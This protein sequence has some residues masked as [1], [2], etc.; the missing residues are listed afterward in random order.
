ML[1]LDIA[2]FIRR[3]VNILLVAVM[4]YTRIPVLGRAKYSED[5]LN[6]STVYLPIVGWLVG[7]ITYVVFLLASY[8]FTPVISLILAVAAGILTTGAFHEDG[9]AD[10]CDGFGGGF[11]KRHILA[12]MQDSRLGTYGV[13]GLVLLFALKA[14][15]LYTIVTD[16]GFLTVLGVFVTGHSLSRWAA[17]ATVFTHEYAREDGK[18]KA[19]PV[20]KALPKRDLVIVS[21]FGLAPLAVSSVLLQNYYLLITVVPVYL[22]KAAASAYFQRRI[23]GY[24]GDCLGA[25]QQLTEV[26]VYLSVLVIWRFAS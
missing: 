9:W 22:V 19:K 15:S 24:T 17:A 1:L 25:I 16:A 13:T 26:T 5:C 21:V 4:F 6:R 12:I 11:T 8:L 10:A 7:V 14:A 3:Q 18:S 2:Y 23:G 20:A